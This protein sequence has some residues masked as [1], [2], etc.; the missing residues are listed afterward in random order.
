[1][2][3]YCSYKISECKSIA[4]D[5]I[6]IN[7]EEDQ[8]M[9]LVNEKVKH[10]SF[11]DGVITEEKDCK[12]WV[13]FQEE[14]GSKIFIYPDAFEKFLRAEDPEVEDSVLEELHSKQE[15]IELEQ[16]ARKEHEA[17]E[18]AE[19]KARLISS[20]KRTSSRGAKKN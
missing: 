17:S 16:R 14:I 13:Q 5:L 8:Q 9:T 20:K 11:G 18:L 4:L 10:I 3:Y 7:F 1:M 12:I 19:R 2:L 15:K 6:L